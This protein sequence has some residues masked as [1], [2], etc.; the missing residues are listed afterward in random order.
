MGP[1]RALS[2]LDYWAEAP[3]VAEPP[4]ETEPPACWRFS[5]SVAA[6]S[7][8]LAP[9]RTRAVPLRAVR[10]VRLVAL[11]APFNAAELLAPAE[12]LWPPTPMPALAPTLGV[13]LLLITALA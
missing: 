1:G 2:R 6:R 7:D 12:A 11:E 5:A 8:A 13:L 4:A 10:A 3:A 9:R